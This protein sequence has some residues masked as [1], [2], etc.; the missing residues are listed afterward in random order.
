MFAAISQMRLMQAVG[1]LCHHTVLLIQ[2]K[3][4]K[5]ISSMSWSNTA[6]MLSQADS[7]FRKDVPGLVSSASPLGWLSACMGLCLFALR[8][9]VFDCHNWPHMAVPSVWQT[10]NNSGQLRKGLLIHLDTGLSWQL[11]NW[12]RNFFSQHNWNLIHPRW[13][14]YLTVGVTAAGQQPH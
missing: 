8:R 7:S 14:Q 2:G 6:K 1:H 9:T 3:K 13:D 10:Q 5:Q 4:S 12:R 11:M